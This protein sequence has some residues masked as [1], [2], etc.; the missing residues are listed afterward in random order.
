MKKLIL[1]GLT[2]FL[3]LSCENKD[4]EV[5]FK[6]LN[7]PVIPKSYSVDITGDHIADLIINYNEIQTN[8]YPHSSAS[9]TGSISPIGNIK[10]LSK[11][12]TG[13]LFLK[14]NDQIFNTDNSQTKWN[15]FSADIVSISRKSDT[16]D[17]SW[18]IKTNDL[19]VFY[20]G[21]KL[22]EGGSEKIGWMQISIDTTNGQIT[23]LKKEITSQK[24][25]IVNSD[26]PLTPTIPTTKLIDVDSDN[27][28][29]FK[30]EYR[31]IQTLDNPSSGAS[32]VGSISPIGNNELLYKSPTGY[33]FLNKN[34]TIFKTNNSKTKWNGF[35]ADIVSISKQS[36]Y[37]DYSW[38]IMNKDLSMF[39]VGIKKIGDGYEKIGWMQLDIDTSNGEIT[40]LKKKITS[41]NNIIVNSD[42]P[43]IQIMPAIKYIDI[44]SDNKSDFKIEYKSLQTADVPS[45]GGSIIGSISPIGNNKLL[46]KYPSGYLFLNKNDTIFRMEN[47]KLKW[48]SYSADVVSISR[49][50]NTWQDLWS[51]MSNH[52]SALYVGIKMIDG[53]SEKIGWM[54]LSI[55]N[56]NGEI[57]I[58]GKTISTSESIEIK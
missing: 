25:I 50:D 43:V 18:K 26:N 54:Q 52:L 44:D 56:T 27:Q 39:Y 32:I 19:S 15:G 58:I 14:K 45:S 48:S 8:D 55:D 40:V 17:N 30:I 2:F 41:Q 7:R 37:W 22:I 9:I 6:E 47:S 35:S 1:I 34:D 3:L 33:L 31:L 4:N 23:I 5:N 13:Y 11:D 20:V 21:I 36:D 42:K 10:F 12:T 57:T 24:N 49:Q 53:D 28:N 16:W 51:I 29:D 38:K 46:Y